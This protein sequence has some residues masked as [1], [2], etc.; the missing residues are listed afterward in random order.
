MGMSDACNRAFFAEGSGYYSYE[1]PLHCL[2]H[3]FDLLS[4]L[5]GSVKEVNVWVLSQLLITRPFTAAW[6]EKSDIEKDLYSILGRDMFELDEKHVYDIVYA[7]S[8]KSPS[9]YK[10]T[11]GDVAEEWRLYRH[12]AGKV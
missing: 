11:R 3:L 1:T 5:K 10:L 4:A 7:L 8:L 6:Y 12:R 9:E 2:Y